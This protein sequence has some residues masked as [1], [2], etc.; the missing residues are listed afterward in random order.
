[1]SGPA[2]TAILSVA[3][4]PRSSDDAQKL[5]EAL[6]Q[7]MAE[8]PALR[9]RPDELAGHV[10]ISGTSEQHLDA[11]VDRVRREFDVEASVGRPEVIYREAVTRPADGE[12]KYARPAGGGGQYAHVKIH[13]YPGEPGTG[14]IFENE[15]TQGSIPREFIKPIDEA[16]KEALTRGVLAGYPIDDVRIVLYDGS[17][18]DVDSSEAAFRTA[19]AVAAQEAARK[20]EPVL[21]EPVMRVDAVV[22]ADGVHDVVKDLVARRGQIHTSQDRGDTYVLRALVPLAELF[23]YATDFRS[24]THGYGTHTMQ[25]D[26]YA[27]LHVSDDD[28]D[29]DSV[30]GAP[31]KPAPNLR[32]SS[33]A[34]P[35]PE[36]DGAGN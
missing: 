11:I 1:M 12:T 6:Q 5:A 19:G 23:D 29:R 9:V 4:R 15:V 14:Y 21:L 33:V 36:A 8:D 30:V 13:L 25:F 34:L 24:R 28:E 22:P 35:E 18:H 26:A 2:G 16:I 32:D 7:L 20:A 27:P 3:I 17:Y 31:R 10:V